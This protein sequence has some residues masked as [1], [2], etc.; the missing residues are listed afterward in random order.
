MT[1]DEE[2]DNLIKEI[3]EVSAPINNNNKKMSKSQFMSKYINDMYKKR[4]RER[5]NEATE[6]LIESA[7]SKRANSEKRKRRGVLKNEY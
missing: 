2:L 7:V 4:Y 6:F 3:G 1:F 5:H